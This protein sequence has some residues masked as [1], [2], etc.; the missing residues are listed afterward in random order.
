MNKTRACSLLTISL[1]FVTTACASSP[2]GSATAI[3]PIVVTAVVGTIAISGNTSVP[4]ASLP[5]ASTPPPTLAPSAP[6]P[7]P[8]IPGG[9]STTELKY[10]LLGQFPDFFFCDPDFYPVARADELDRARQLFPE[11]QA[12]TGEFNAI[13]AHNNLTG[14]TTFS[15][16]Q[17]L[18]IYRQYKKLAALQLKLAGL[19][20]QFQLQLKN[21]DGG[22]ELV[23]GVIDGQGNITIQQRKPSI[24]TCPIC[25]AIG[26]RIDTPA[27]AVPVQDLR[28]GMLVWTVDKAGVRV[29]QPVLEVSRT[30]VPSDHQVVHLVLDDGRQLWV[31]PGHPT[32]DGRRV[33][34]LQVGDLLDGA[35]VLSASLVAYAGSATYDLL[36]AGDSGFYWANGILLGST[37]SDLQK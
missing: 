3:P 31:S 7:I 8:T 35:Q 32:S 21:A 26:T 13:L 29:A 34:Q 4:L 25:L 11:M 20:Y 2:A 24:A 19:N 18:L 9:L 33:G 17:K 6:T 14:L 23:T 5:P 10:R 36:P 12:N 28:V 16:D 30:V 15:D 22:G 1:I 27:G 37:L